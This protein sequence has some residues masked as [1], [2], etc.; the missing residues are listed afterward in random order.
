[1][2]RRHKIAYFLSLSLSL[3]P[4]FSFPIQVIRFSLVAFVCTYFKCAMCNCSV[5]CLHYLAAPIPAQS[6][7]PYN[8]NCNCNDSDD[9]VERWNSKQNEKEKSKKELQLLAAKYTYINIGINV[10]VNAMEIWE[11]SKNCIRRQWH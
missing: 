5:E 9:N 3:A 4:Y 7:T 11:C 2:Y 6:S 10:N 1:M 8:D